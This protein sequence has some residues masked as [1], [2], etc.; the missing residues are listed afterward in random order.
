MP[1]IRKIWFSSCMAP[2]G[3]FR[4]VHAPSS[5]E[6]KTLLIIKT[7]LKLI[8]QCLYHE[9]HEILYDTLPP[10]SAL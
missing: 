9:Y 5:L 3:L 6:S 10:S 8:E 4:Q 2:F 7:T 1:V